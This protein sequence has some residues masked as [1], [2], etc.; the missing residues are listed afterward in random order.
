MPLTSSLTVQLGAA[1]TRVDDIGSTA[2]DDLL[3]NFAKSLANGTGANQADRVW[4]DQ[5]TLAASANEDLDLAGA[6]TDALGGSAVFARVKAIVVRASDANT[7]NVVVGGAASNQFVG[8][9]GAGT[10]TVAVKPGG[11]FAVFAADAT[12]WAVTAGTGDLLRIANSAGS[13]AV[14]YDIIIIGASA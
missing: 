12:A 3:W 14:T 5:R 2:R 10:H 8:P 1:L 7:N 13:T 4:R 11:I 6:L 9:F